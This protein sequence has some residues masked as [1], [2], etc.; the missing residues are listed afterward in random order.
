MDCKV[1]LGCSAMLLA[2]LPCS[3][4]YSPRKPLNKH[5][6]VQALN[7]KST[8]PETAAGDTNQSIERTSDQSGKL[9]LDVY[10]SQST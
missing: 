1:S 3:S 4:C 10:R 6:G 5:V 9:V 7:Y 8:C 2:L